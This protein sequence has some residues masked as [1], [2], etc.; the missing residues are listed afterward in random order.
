MGSRGVRGVVR[1]RDEGSGK[2]GGE[3][4]RGVRAGE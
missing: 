3:G 2:E 4:E 1:R